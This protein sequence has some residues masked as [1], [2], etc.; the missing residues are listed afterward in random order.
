[1]ANNMKYCPTCHDELDTDCQGNPRCPNCD[2]PCPCCNDGPG[3]GDTTERD[4][5][6][7]LA[8]R[9]TAAGD[10]AAFEEIFGTTDTHFDLHT[11]DSEQIQFIYREYCQDE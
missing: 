7:D 2:D 6:E 10:L 5:V 1:M 3:P 11:L 8:Q 4:E 9:L